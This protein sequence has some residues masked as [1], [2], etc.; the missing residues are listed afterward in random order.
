MN[1][2][3]KP[4]QIIGRLCKARA[5]LQTIEAL[6]IPAVDDAISELN[7]AILDLCDV[8][9][10]NSADGDFDKADLFVRD[11]LHD[12]LERFFTSDNPENSERLVTIVRREL[13]KGA[14]LN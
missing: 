10:D 5:A 9:L 12:V 11:W 2:K 3:A 14:D 8:P 4:E 6:E 1:E 7:H 13:N